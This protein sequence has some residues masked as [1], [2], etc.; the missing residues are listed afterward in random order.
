MTFILQSNQG[1][2]SLNHYKDNPSVV[3]LWNY[4]ASELLG[5]INTKELKQL[6]QRDE[7]IIEFVDSENTALVSSIDAGLVW[8]EAD[9]HGEQIWQTLGAFS[10]KDIDLMCEVIKERSK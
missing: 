9:S 1:A 8:V 7:Y 3:E 2:Y 4:L 5:M 10:I 6:T